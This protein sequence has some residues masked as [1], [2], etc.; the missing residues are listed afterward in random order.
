MTDVPPH[1]LQ[2]PYP[3]DL[4][5]CCMPASD[6][7]SLPRCGA[8]G[9]QALAMDV[10]WQFVLYPAD[11]RCLACRDLVQTDELEAR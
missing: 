10:P 2:P 7:R 8:E 3:D 1:L 6:G 5:H 11:T 4:V 9:G